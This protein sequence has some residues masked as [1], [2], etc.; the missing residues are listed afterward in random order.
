[1]TVEAGR[2]WSEEAALGGRAFFQ[3]SV[4]P[5][6]LTI[7]NVKDADAGVY[8]CR[9]DFRKSPTRNTKVNLT[10]ILPPEQLSVLDEKG[11][12]IPHYILGPYN[13]GATVDITCISTGGRPLPKLTWWQENALLDDSYEVI[14]ERKVRNVLRVT[15]LER[16][17]LHAVFTCQASNNNH[18]SPI[19]SAVT[20]DMNLRPLWVKLLGQNRPLSSENTYEISCEVV[21]ARPPPLITW[22]KGS[23]QLRNTRETTSTDGNRTV[24]TLSLVPT[25]EDSGK[26]LSCRAVNS[27]IPD[28]G[29]EDGWKLN[30]YHV[31]IVSLEL[32]TNLN[33]SWIREG[34]DVYFECNIKSNPWVYR[35]SWRR[36]GI[37]VTN[38]LNG[39]TILANQSLVLQN[40]DRA[41]A[42]LYTCVASNQ[43]G[44]GESNPLYLDV[45]FVPVCR[46]G[47]ANIIGVGKG[48]L[49]RVP[50]EIETNPPATEYVWKFNNTGE[51][52]EIPS[53]HFTTEPTHSIAT[54]TPVTEHDFGTLLCWAKNALGT[55]KQPCAYHI[56]PAG[57]PD[58]LTNC[59][60]VNQTETSLGVECS[61]GF[62]G[63]LQQQFVMEVFESTKR[64]LM[65][66]I[67]SVTPVL[68]VA[69]LPPGLEYQVAVYAINAK[70][71]S[72]YTII[73]TYT[74]KSPQKRTAISPVVLQFIPLI[75]IL[76]GVVATLV[77]VAT[78]VVLVLR[79]REKNKTQ[80]GEEANSVKQHPLNQSTDSLDNNPDIIP[81]SSEYQGTDEK[82]LERNMAHYPTELNFKS[83]KGEVTYAELSLA[84]TCTVYSE[85]LSASGE[86][87]VYAQ[88]DQGNHMNHLPHHT[89]V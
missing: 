70:G 75:G 10:V 24:S 61:E 31:P 11:E 82:I 4:A 32:G 2:H 44:D 78:C 43:E 48:E 33:G 76:S 16:R 7:E 38:N 55:M 14:S 53:T 64:I 30:I 62:D 63:G 15:Q 22:W 88:I 34:V 3:A 87:T 66:N 68:A 59:S 80:K 58:S 39:G 1:M 49:A 6:R 20:L 35:V 19:S 84:G 85:L 46:P 26:Y 67:S 52:V 12:H 89:T 25:M 72:D 54:Y 50:C 45:K 21:G 83:P 51:N 81:L 74:L 29:M 36:N 42:G 73:H 69:G 71:R 65:A 47:Q 56:I 41:R 79:C 27:L 5:A 60:L 77:A 9:V 23:I 17:H 40:V 37:P 13:E 18:L 57:R 28:S 86:P 8:R